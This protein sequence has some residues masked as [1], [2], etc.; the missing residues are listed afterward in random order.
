MYHGCLVF[1]PLY[2]ALS[3]LYK[4]RWSDIYKASAVLATVATLAQCLNFALEGS[5]ADFM[6]LRYGNGNPF[7]FLLADTPIL[8]YLLLSVLCVGGLSLIIAIT[9]GLRA[10]VSRIKSKAKA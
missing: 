5:G 2:M 10:L 3:G 4:P 7:A 9:I 8:Y 1:V 6:T